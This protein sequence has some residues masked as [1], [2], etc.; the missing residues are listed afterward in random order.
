MTL[1][2]ATMFARYAYPPN[3]LGYCGPEDASPLLNRD[4]DAE[5]LIAR[6]A[7][8]FEGA[9]TYLELI[10]SAAAIADPLDERVVEAYWVGNDLLDGIDP[11][12]TLA[13]LRRRFVGQNDASWMPGLPHHSF[14]VFTVYPWVGLLSRA[15]N[16]AVAVSVLEQCRIRWGEVLAVEGDRLRVRSQPLTFIDGRLD[17]GPD[18]DETAAWSVDG[19]SVLPAIAVGDHV[20]LHWDWVCDVLDER[21]LSEL[22]SRSACQLAATNTVLAG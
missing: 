18:R 11:V 8:E 3:V 1:N 22:E 2:G 17:L 9:W 19:T 13:E 20:A 6:H 14:H 5:A 7:R 16:R 15:A 10:A 21:Q 4:S 12:A